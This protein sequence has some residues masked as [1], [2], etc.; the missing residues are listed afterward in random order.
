[1]TGNHRYHLWIKYASLVALCFIGTC[2]VAQSQKVNGLIVSRQGETLNVQSPDS[3]KVIVLLTPSTQVQEPQGKLHMRKKS[4][5]VTALVPGL[6]IKVD[7]TKNPAGQLVADKISFS[8]KDLKT[9]N[10]IQAGMKATEAQVKTNQAQDQANE[11]ESQ[12]NQ[13]KIAE[14]NKRFSE[15]SDYDVKQTADVHFPP[16][17]TTLSESDKAALM[18]LAQKAT[19]EKGYLIS[20]KGFA[21]SSGNAVQN[22]KLSMDRADAVLEYLEQ[23]GKVPLMHI[24]APGAMG[25]ADPAATNETPQGRAE[26]RRV[27]VKVLQNRG[28]A[29]EN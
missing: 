2:L 9:A 29:A 27:E 4:M 25:T 6:S 1:M 10:E 12:A 24:V 5:A 8:A 26:N 18:Q 15:L 23:D 14:A 7:G 20:V 22:E 17:S 16:G 21:D 11:A 13:Q 3:S 19:A 28:L